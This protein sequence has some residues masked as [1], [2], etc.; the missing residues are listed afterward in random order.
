VPRAYV[1]EH[2]VRINVARDIQR[3]LDQGPVL[4]LRFGKLLRSLRDTLLRFVV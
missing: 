3:V 4:G 1:A 2:T